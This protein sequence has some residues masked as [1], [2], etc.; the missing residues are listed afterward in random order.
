MFAAQR[1]GWIQ[2]VQEWSGDD[3]R[4]LGQESWVHWLVLVFYLFVPDGC[5]SGN[6]FFFKKKPTNSYEQL[7]SK[8]G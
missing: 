1:L 5:E 4:G 6:G 7:F 3:D 2:S 8:L